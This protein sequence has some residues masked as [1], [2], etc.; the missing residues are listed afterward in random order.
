MIDPGFIVIAIFVVLIGGVLL[1][2][3]SKSG[4]RAANDRTPHQ[5]GRRLD[6]ADD[7]NGGGFM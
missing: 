6:G 7:I 4:P 3:R 5:P 1:S 2:R